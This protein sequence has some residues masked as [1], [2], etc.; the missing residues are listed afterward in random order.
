MKTMTGFVFLLFAAACAVSAAEEPVTSSAPAAATPTQAAPAPSEVESVPPRT[1]PSHP[2]PQTTASHTLAPPD[3]HGAEYKGY[4]R[5]VFDGQELYCRNDVSTG[6]HANR[7]PVCL[8]EAQMKSQQ[9]AV[10]LMLDDMIRRSAAVQWPTN[11]QGGMSP[12][13]RH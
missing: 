11:F 1:I 5:I 12:G 10:Q 6:S 4:Q 8:T 7:K 3:G 9:L 13:G 2:D